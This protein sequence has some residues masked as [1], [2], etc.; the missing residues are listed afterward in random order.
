M[1]YFFLTD[2][3]YF[4]EFQDFTIYPAQRPGFPEKLPY[5]RAAAATA[6]HGEFVNFPN[7]VDKSINLWYFAQTWRFC[8]IA[9]TGVDNYNCS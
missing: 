9:Q 1:K 8:V 6:V 7:Y 4:Q 3:K 2:E 5:T